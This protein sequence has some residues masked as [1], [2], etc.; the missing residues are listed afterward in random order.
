L[1]KLASRRSA[2]SASGASRRSLG[3]FAMRPGH[4]T[5]GRT[6]VRVMMGPLIPWGSCSITRPMFRRLEV[7][8]ASWL[9]GSR[10]LRR[11]SLAGDSVGCPR[12]PSRPGG[13]SMSASSTG[14]LPWDL[15][16]RVHRRT[17]PSMA[18]SPG[19]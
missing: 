9:T 15:R 17:L 7:M 10:W 14:M 13:I 8:G 1:G 18:S 16:Q 12:G 11:E 3:P 2:T 6:L 4:R 19:A 5:S